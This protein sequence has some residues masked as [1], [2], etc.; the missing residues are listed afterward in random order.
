VAPVRVLATLCERL[1]EPF[2]I[3]PPIYRRRVDFFTKSRSFDIRRATTLLR[4]S[5][6]VGIREGVRRTADWYR[7]Q[8]LL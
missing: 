5:P 4:Y 6:A 8:G 2:K 1:C 7:K 3:P